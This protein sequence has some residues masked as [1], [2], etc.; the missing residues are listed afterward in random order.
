MGR[1]LPIIPMASFKAK[2]IMKKDC[3]KEAIHTMIMMEKNI[4]TT[5]IVKEMLSIIGFSI[6]KVR[7]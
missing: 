3:W 5:H 2:A 1:L 7:L 6:K 4:T